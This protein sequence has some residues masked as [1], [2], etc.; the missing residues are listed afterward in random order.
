MKALVV[1]DTAT[2]LALVCQL[3][4]G[5]GITPIQAR[6]GMTGVRLFEE[7]PPDIILLD[8]ILPDIDGFEVARRI[9]SME[10]TGDWTPI[11]FLTGRTKDEDLEQGISA[12]GD[13]YILK[14]VSKVVLTAKVRA[15][16][17]IMQM[18]HSLL[19]VTHKLDTANHEL[20]RLSAMDGLTGIPN[21][22]HFDESLAREW[23]RAMRD[24]KPLSL[25]MC[26]ID[27]FKQFNDTYGH[28]AG[29]ACLKSVANLLQSS[30]RRPGDII[31]RYGGEEFAAILPETAREGALLVAENMRALVEDMGTAHSGVASGIVTISVGV[32]TLL[33]QLVENEPLLIS[34]ADT[35]L[36][37]AKR[38]GRNCVRTA[39]LNQ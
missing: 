34:A 1:E 25:L 12:G 28:Q 32:A 22:R 29:D 23:R 18:R 27:G 17:R 11:I 37:E 24:K 21:R 3:L 7:N 36:Y 13:D 19:K 14:P 30:L 39:D 16:Q 33:P 5:M 2:G 15:M 35:A 6:D 8:I 10:K 20:K 38:A 31:A 4:E 9:R 26:D